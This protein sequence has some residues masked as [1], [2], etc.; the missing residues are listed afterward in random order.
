MSKVVL[1]NNLPRFSSNVGKVIDDGL[2]ELA[3]DILVKSRMV[4]PFKFGPLRSNSDINRKSLMHWQVRY[5]M[6]Y[7]YVQEKG[8]IK[9]S[10]IRNYTTAGTG[11][12]YLSKTGDKE[13]KKAISTLKKH[14]RR[15]RA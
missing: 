14:A 13:F 7:A 8:S 10:P 1:V 2:K 5:H 12:K 11:S 15:A 9:G 4:A 6:E 3:R